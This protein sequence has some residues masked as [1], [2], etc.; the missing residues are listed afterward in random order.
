M[1]HNDANF[2]GSYLRFT[3]ASSTVKERRNFDQ[4]SDKF[5]TFIYGYII[6]IIDI[7]YSMEI[8][9]SRVNASRVYLYRVKINLL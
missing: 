2:F 5:Q 7:I 1:T 6:V 9:D 8:W 4:Y 3:R